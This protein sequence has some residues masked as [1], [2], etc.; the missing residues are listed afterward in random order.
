[1]CSCL[2]FVLVNNPPKLF[3][4]A[5][6]RVHINSSSTYLFSVSDPNDTYVVNLRGSLPASSD[7]SLS[8]D[9]DAYNFTWTPT[10]FSPVRLL[11]IANDSLGSTAIL[12]PEVRICGCALDL[13]ATCV[14]SNED[15]GD[16]LFIIQDCKCGSG[17]LDRVNCQCCLCASYK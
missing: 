10:S 2:I 9:G 12:H 3:G 6:F 15:G 5:T 17:R 4:N 1:M 8:H 13:N 7:Y 14:E 16:D 11:F